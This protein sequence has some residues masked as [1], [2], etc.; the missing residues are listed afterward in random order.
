MRSR[1]AGDDRQEHFR[2][3]RLVTERR[4]WTHSIVVASPAF[5]DDRGLAQRVEDLALEQLI[6]QTRVEARNIAILP[7]AAAFDIG[8]LCSHCCDP[9]LDSLG[10]DL[11]P[12]VGTDM[13]GHSAQDEEIGQHIDHV[14]GFQFAIDTDRQTLAR[15]LV[16]NVEHAIS[17]PVMRAIFEEIVRPDV[18]GSLWPQTDAG[19]VGQP[20]TP[21]FGLLVWDFQPLASPDALNPAIA[22]HP[23][24]PAQQGCNLAVAVATIL[25]SQFDDICRQPLRIHA[26]LWQLPLRRA[27]LPERRTGATLGHLQLT[28][29]VL[30]AGTARGLEVSP[31]RLLKNQLVQ[32]Q[33]G[34]RFTQPT[35]LSLEFLQTLYLFDLQPAKLLA[36]AV[37]GHLAHTDLTDRLCRALSL[38]NQHINLPKLRYNLLRL[39][40]LTCHCS[41]P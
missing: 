25:A 19:A 1:P 31:V 5:D 36:P 9:L 14:D 17:P 37:I 21:T 30:N 32:R 33:I 6:A 10:H 40:S 8:G 18:I 41:P 4:V 16:D 2:Y 3:W 23:A 22:N 27:M 28:A 34:N 39:V 11:G 7:W 13:L 15:E 38:R 29:D 26:T 20:K 35:I 24:G 12:V